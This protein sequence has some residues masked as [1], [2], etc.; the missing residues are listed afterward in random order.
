[1][2]SCHSNCP[3]RLPCAENA[4][5]LCG[6]PNHSSTLQLKW[7]LQF[8]LQPNLS[9]A[10]ALSPGQASSPILQLSSASPVPISLSCHRAHCPPALPS[11]WQCC[12]P[13]HFHGAGC[14]WL[15]PGF[16]P[17]GSRAGSR[18]LSTHCWVWYYHLEW[19]A[20]L[21]HLICS[22]KP[23]HAK[24]V[25]CQWE[26]QTGQYSNG[27]FYQCCSSQN[28]LHQSLINAGRLFSRVYRATLESYHSLRD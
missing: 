4:A 22:T 1:M 2:Q 14:P 6:Y 17:G 25:F 28:H 26:L 15:G 19:L 8:L 3:L 23:S 7:Q 9:P 21:Q 16:P 20:F 13:C 12:K 24:K 11:P 10:E 27:S 5:M 18:S